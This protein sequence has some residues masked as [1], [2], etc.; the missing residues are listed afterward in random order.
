MNYVKTK[1]APIIGAPL[2]FLKIT[3]K[4]IKFPVE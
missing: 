3:T 1:G 2:F 4:L